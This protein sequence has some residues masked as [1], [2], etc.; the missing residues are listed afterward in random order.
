MTEEERQKY[1]AK[2]EAMTEEEVDK[3]IIEKEAE[4][5]SLEQ[6]LAENEARIEYF[7]MLERMGLDEFIEW[8]EV[9]DD[10]PEDPD[11]IYI[12]N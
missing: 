10:E 7:E 9:D 5:K 12:R 1:L 11:Y 4:I 2:I 3:H 8:E 6:Q